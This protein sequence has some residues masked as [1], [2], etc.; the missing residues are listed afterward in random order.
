MPKKARYF[1]SNQHNDVM[2][3]T[4]WKC[5]VFLSRKKKRDLPRRSNRADLLVMQHLHPTA[6][7]LFTFYFSQTTGTR[8][9]L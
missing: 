2:I 5:R 6:P 3:I 8:A 9:R 4:I 7:F 1:W